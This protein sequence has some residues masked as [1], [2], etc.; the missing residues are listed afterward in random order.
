MDCDEFDRLIRLAGQS[1]DLDQRCNLLQRAVAL[2]KGPFLE[3]CFL[4]WALALQSNYEQLAIQA[5]LELSVAEL[6]RQRWLSALQ[7]A[8]QAL[9]IDPLHRQAA[10]SVV[11]SHLGAG[12]PK[13]ALQF[14]EGFKARY[15]E[16]FG[17]SLQMDELL[18]GGAAA[19]P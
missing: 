9:S 15:Q 11:K 14:F 12:N 19:N 3:G 8:N 2:Y 5:L 6:S 7:T 16:E 10:A 4:D 18:S 17:Q 13:L 1:K